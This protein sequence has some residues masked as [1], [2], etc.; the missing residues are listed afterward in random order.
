METI[1]F[2][3]LEE[4]SADY[5]SINDDSESEQ[6]TTLERHL[7]AI[8]NYANDPFHTTDSAITALRAG[9]ADLMKMCALYGEAVLRVLQNS[10]RGIE[11]LRACAPAV[12][13]IIRL[14]KQ[15]GQLADLERRLSRCEIPR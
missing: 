6:T 5:S 7:R 10:P 2:S 4:V 9:N 12:D 11:E 13:L 3:E 15:E 1:D 14:N 8:E